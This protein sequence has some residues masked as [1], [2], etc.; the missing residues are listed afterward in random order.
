MA[1][2]DEACRSVSLCFEDIPLD[3][4]IKRGIFPSLREEK[5]A[6]GRPPVPLF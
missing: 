2:D 6:G 3:S 1:F 4:Y 5:E